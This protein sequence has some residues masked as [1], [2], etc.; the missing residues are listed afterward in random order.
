TPEFWRPKVRL[1]PTF[2]ESYKSSYILP[3]HTKSPTIPIKPTTKEVTN[4]CI[5]KR[6]KNSRTVNQGASQASYKAPYTSD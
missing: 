5:I 4:N 3:K 2:L 1:E 6:R